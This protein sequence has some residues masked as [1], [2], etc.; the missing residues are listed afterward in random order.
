MTSQIAQTLRG[1]GGF[2]HY[3]YRFNLKDSPYFA[4][5]P[6]QNNRMF[7][8]LS[9]SVICLCASVQTWKWKLTAGLGNGTSD[10]AYDSEIS[11]G[12]SEKATFS[13]LILLI[14]TPDTK[15]GYIVKER[16]SITVRCPPHGEIDTSRLR[17]NQLSRSSSAAAARR[18]AARPAPTRLLSD[19]Y[20]VPSTCGYF[21]RGPLR[22]LLSY[23]DVERQFSLA[24]CTDNEESST[25]SGI[26]VIFPIVLRENFRDHKR[27]MS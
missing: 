23:A 4:C 16:L 10:F 12:E 5:D 3:L 6:A 21:A 7:C 17:F 26:I 9:K 15:S 20:F 2:A 27:E 14:L 18:Q 22:I 13:K 1:R 11:K 8:T 19:L 25:R 24:F